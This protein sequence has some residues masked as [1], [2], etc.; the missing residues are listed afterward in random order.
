MVAPDGIETV[1]GTLAPPVAESATVTPLVGAGPTNVT[2]PVDEAPPTTEVGFRTKLE[3]PI[4]LMVS[5]ALLVLLRKE[6]EIVDVVLEETELVEIVNDPDDVPAA[7]VTD[8]GT[9]APLVAES[10]TTTPPV[11]AELAS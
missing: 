1:A 2:V 5:T 6:A 4:G 7:I 11:G 9:I 10:L 3:T 8:A